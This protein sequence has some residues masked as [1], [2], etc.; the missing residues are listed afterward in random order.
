M[1]DTT[2]RDRLAGELL[3]VL[4]VASNFPERAQARLLGHDMRPLA[5]KCAAAI[6][7]AGWRPPTRTV[8][9]VEEV[10]ALPDDTL[11]LIACHLSNLVYEAD[12]GEAWR[13]G[14]GYDIRLDPE[15]LPATVIY[16]PGEDE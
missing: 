16:E 9:T 4:A 15:L 10:E 7:K 3:S 13:V 6:L 2:A 14:Y 8:S 1:N 11:L 12:G 5:E